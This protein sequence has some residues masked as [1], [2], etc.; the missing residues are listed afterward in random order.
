MGATPSV[1]KG[2]ISSVEKVGLQA[3]PTPLGAVLFSAKLCRTASLDPGLVTKKDFIISLRLSHDYWY[4]CNVRRP[5]CTI[6]STD[7]GVGVGLRV[8]VIRP[9]EGAPGLSSI[10]VGLHQ[11]HNPYS[12]LYM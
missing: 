10:V 3:I 6:Q 8:R 9:I 4:S 1:G 7:Y 11:R 2:T 5:T 12:V